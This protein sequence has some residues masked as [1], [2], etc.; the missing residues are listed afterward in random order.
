VLLRRVN[1]MRM[2]TLSVAF[3]SLRSGQLILPNPDEFAFLSIHF[4]SPQSGVTRSSG[5]T[6][7]CLSDRS[8]SATAWRIRRQG[9]RAGAK[10]SVTGG[11][12]RAIT[13][14]IST[15]PDDG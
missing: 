6:A 12:D 2:L 4:R 11:K 15:I 14:A 3:Y 13:A 8:L 1:L 10:F 9:Q 5:A 7:S